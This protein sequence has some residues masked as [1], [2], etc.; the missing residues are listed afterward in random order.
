MIKQYIY[1]NGQKIK[2][3]KDEFPTLN[4]KPNNTIERLYDGA[5]ESLGINKLM[6]VELSIPKNISNYAMLGVKYENNEETK[7]QIDVYDYDTKEFADNLGIKPDYIQIGIPKDYVVG[8]YKG[9]ENMIISGIFK[10]GKY[11]FFT[12]AHGEVGSSN[13]IFQDTCMVILN[14]LYETEVNKELVE[15]VLKSVI[16]N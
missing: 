1:E 4:C 11:R 13:S 3:W 14:L 8:I 10:K 15:D 6:V 16:S 7:V 5:V 2:I 12:G 9:I